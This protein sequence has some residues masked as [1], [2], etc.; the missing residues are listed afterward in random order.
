MRPINLT[1]FQLSPFVNDPKFPENR[2]SVNWFFTL[3]SD[4]AVSLHSFSRFV[5]SFAFVNC[6]GAR[7]S[8]VGA[9]MLLQRVYVFTPPFYTASKIA[10]FTKLFH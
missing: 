5:F 6:P 8:M 2:P 1:T 9:L 10:F 3:L 4:V 7:N